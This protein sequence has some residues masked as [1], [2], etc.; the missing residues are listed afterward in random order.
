[1]KSNNTGFWIV[2]TVAAIG[3]V[4]YWYYKTKVENTTAVKATKWWLNW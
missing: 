1:M 4:G 2:I 3:G